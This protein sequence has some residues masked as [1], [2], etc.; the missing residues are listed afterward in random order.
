MS[1]PLTAAE[2]T[3]SRMIARQAG[4]HRALGQHEAADELVAKA[5]AALEQAR[6]AERGW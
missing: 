6:R 3:W 4:Q 1:K 2:K 5:A